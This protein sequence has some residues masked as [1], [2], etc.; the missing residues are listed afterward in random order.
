[1]ICPASCH[2]TPP[3]LA[4]P[5]AARCAHSPQGHPGAHAECVPYQ[6]EPA[7]QLLSIT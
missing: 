1:M 2:K 7:V 4:V 5:E 6:G 3:Q